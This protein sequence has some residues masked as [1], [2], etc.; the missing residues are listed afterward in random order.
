M[1]SR[2]NAEKNHSSGG[3][4]NEGDSLSIP[5]SHEDSSLDQANISFAQLIL[6]LGSLDEFNVLFCI[7]VIKRGKTHTQKK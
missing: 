5:P 3:L 6:P 4:I 2:I 1:K 7:F